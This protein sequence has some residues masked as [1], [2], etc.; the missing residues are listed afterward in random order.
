MDF[1]ELGKMIADKAP[2]IGTALGSLVLPGAG[3]AV[4]TLAGNLIK[5]YFGT[6]T[7]D[8]EKLAEIVQQDPQAAAKLMLAEYEFK[9]EFK[10]L[11]LEEQKAFLAD[12]QGAR[13]REV[14]IT[15]VT[16]KRDALQFCLAIFGVSAPV[17]L[18]IYLI[19]WGMPTMS[20]EMAFL[21][22]GFIG[23][24]IGEYKTIFGYFFGSSRGSAEK[25]NLLQDEL[26]KKIP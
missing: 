20:A 5:K 15:K 12:V 2:L 13:Q 3:S 1:G 14:E 9:L 19:K 24:I 26:K 23:I 17:F 8:S 11:D 21:V 16:G 25:T 4:G 22:G 7:D 10:K 18:I 6:V